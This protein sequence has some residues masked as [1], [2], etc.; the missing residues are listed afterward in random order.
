MT[1]K[2]QFKSSRNAD[3]TNDKKS[4]EEPKS[5]TP[6]AKKAV[7]STTKG[8]EELSKENGGG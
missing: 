7:Q 5:N 2:L 6:E 3:A 8:Q 4:Q 1:K